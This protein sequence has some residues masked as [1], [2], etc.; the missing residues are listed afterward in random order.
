MTL[1]EMRE[2][3]NAVAT[4]LG[5]L[6]QAEKRSTE[7][8]GR[9]DALLAEFNDLGPKVEREATIQDSAAKAQKM[10][11][12]RGRVS[13][14]VPGPVA[15]QKAAAPQSIGRKFAQAE[16]IQEWRTSPGRRSDAVDVGSFRPELTADSMS[17][18]EQRA[19]V[20]T[21]ALPADMILP[22]FVPGVFRG[23]EAPL[24]MRDVLISGSTTADAITFMRE[25]TFTNAAVEVAQATATAGATG[26]KPESALTFEQATAPVVTIAHWIPITRQTIDD[27]PQLQTYVEQRLITGLARREDA[28]I[29]NGDGTGANMT[30]ILTTTGV[31]AI[32]AA[33]FTATPVRDAGFSNENINRLRRAKRMVRVTGMAVPNFVVLHPVQLETFETLT[34]AQRNYLIGDV[35]GGGAVNR[36]WGM[37]VV[38]SENI[39]TTTALVGD[40]T[41]AAVWDRQQARV[42]IDTINDQ[43]VRNMLTLLAE[44]RLALAVY[45]PSAFAAV[46]LL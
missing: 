12:S 46:T 10:S 17:P 13:G 9:L 45:R 4:E 33:H 6:A 32:N 3:L 36:L 28:Q 7:D 42:L 15:E 31:Q 5:T 24:S 29:L 25:L 18:A 16:A 2:R 8:E 30:G 14:V 23:I 44:E 35:I 34:D 1:T 40:G 37:R 41:M 21:G 19:L 26:L 43:F 27:A 39:A 20:Y 38:E 22:S 11:E